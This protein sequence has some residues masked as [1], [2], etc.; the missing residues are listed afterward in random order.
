MYNIWLSISVRDSRYRV[1][2]ASTNVQRTNP[3]FDST[4]IQFSRQ[5][6]NGTLVTQLL[7]ARLQF[8]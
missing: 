1:I 7:V 8:V 6:L 3:P 2:N 4:L 5:L